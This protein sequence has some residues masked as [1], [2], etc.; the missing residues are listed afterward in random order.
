MRINTDQEIVYEGPL[1]SQ[2]PRPQSEE[3]YVAYSYTGTNIREVFDNDETTIYE[4]LQNIAADFT[5]A[6]E[7]EIIVDEGDSF[8]SISVALSVTTGTEN[9]AF[10]GNDNF[11]HLALRFT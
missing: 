4:A 3:L 6:R 9:I 7:D 10:P 8:D 5:N 2:Y 1:V 11:K